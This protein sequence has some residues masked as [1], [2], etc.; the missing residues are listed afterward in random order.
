MAK[1]STAR[2]VRLI[3]LCVAVAVPAAVALSYGIA[4][5][6]SPVTPVEGSG[7][8]TDPKHMNT[9]FLWPGVRQPAALKPHEANLPDNEPVVGV[10]AGGRQRAYRTHALM[11][12][13]YHVINDLLGEVPVTVT[14]DD[15]TER[16][17]VFTGESGGRA[18]EVWMAGYYDG[19]ILR[20]DGRYFRQDTGR[21][22]AAPGQQTDQ[23]LATMPHTRTDW[24]TWYT[25]YPETDVFVGDSKPVT[26]PLPK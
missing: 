17:Q 10:S 26:S 1:S 2:W 11:G 13:T 24:K 7:V 8:S 5:F 4:W 20:L 23:A 6:Q 14:F 12:I 22:M 3:A 15:R 18:L 19:M 25:A 21:Y 9:P 16:A